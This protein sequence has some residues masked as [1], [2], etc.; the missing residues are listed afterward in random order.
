MFNNIIYFIIVLLIFNTNFPGNTPENSLILSFNMFFI[1]W[2][3]FAGY[4]HY[5]FRGLKNKLNHAEV[6]DGRLTAQYHRLIVRLSV[7]AIFLFALAIYLF[8]LKYW[9]RMIP[10]FERFSV[11]QGL[12]ALSLFFFYLGTIWYFAWTAYKAIFGVV[13]ERRSFII[14]NIKLNLPILFPWMILSLVY[15]LVSLSSWAGPDGI[16][17]TIEGQII[18]FACFITLLMIFIP[19]LI[20]YWWG[21]KPFKASEKAVQL[22]DFLRDRGFKCRGLLKWPIFEGRMMTAGIMGIIPRFRYILITDSLMEILSIDELKSVVAHEMGHAR[23]RHLLF[24]ILFFVGFMVLSFGLSDFFFYLLY[25]QPFLMNMML[26]KDSQSISLLYLIFS[27]PMLI[28]LFV[29][30]RYVMGFFMRNFE[31]QADLYSA[32]TMGTPKF[33]INSLE[34]IA[35]LGGKSRDLPSWHHFSIRE[36]VEYLSQMPGDPDLIRRHN[37]FVAI[38]FLTYLIFLAC[39]GYF[40]NFSSIKQRLAYSM[41]EKT[42]GQQ[43]QKEPDNIALYRDLAMVYH[44]MEEHQEAIKTYEVIIKLDPNQAVCLNNLAWLLV[45]APHEELRNSERALELARKADS[46]EKSP[47]FLDTLAEAYYANGFTRE[48]VETIE[49]AIALATENRAYYEKQLKKF[50]AS[51]N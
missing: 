41:V 46:L 15:D 17:N 43:I 25:S 38:S 26:S 33:V 44:H 23:Y 34:K 9:L 39:L 31:R 27:I 12:L 47:V 14:S 48:A 5:V 32:V 40:L 1:S 29:Y 16:L 22:E 36:R 24:Y 21:C 45:T 13:I 10:G 51:K 7:L 8:S 6:D 4:C 11:L 18:F 28:S 2:L 42:L 30:F 49:E 3:V 50:L 35:Y 37:R 20:Q 19:G